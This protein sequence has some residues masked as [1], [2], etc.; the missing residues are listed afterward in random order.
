MRERP[1]SVTVLAIINLVL[2]G[3]GFLGL[4]VGLVFRLGLIPM[5]GGQQN[6]ALE[7]M[8]TNV[9]YRVF[10][11][12]SMVLMFLATIWI[13]SAS[14]GMFQL[15]PWAR[16]ATIGWGVYSI[17]MKVIGAVL[18]HALLTLPMLD[19]ASS[20]QERTGMMIGLV[21]GGCFMLVIL[22]YYLVMIVMLMRPHV[23][24]AFK[25]DTLD[26]DVYNPPGHVPDESGG[27]LR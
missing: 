19:Q 14:L 13:I 20:S 4:L 8:E 7:L 16:L 18:Q 12:V 5:P 24:E 25:P 11:D 3:L 9:A 2:A 22:G 21:V 27:A 6:P 1:T 26:D 23:V 17:I 10:S 15:K